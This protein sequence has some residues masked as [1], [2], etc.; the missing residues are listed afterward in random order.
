M[1]TAQVLLL[2]LWFIVVAD[3]R[4]RRPEPSRGARLEILH[5]NQRW[6]CDFADEVMCHIRN[7]PSMPM[8]FVALPNE[9]F[10]GRRGVYYLSHSAHSCAHGGARLYTP[11]FRLPPE[12]PACLE[13]SYWAFGNALHSMSVYQQDEGARKVWQRDNFRTSQD[14]CWTMAKINITPHNKRVPTRFFVE[15]KFG[16]I[17]STRAGFVLISKLSIMSHRCV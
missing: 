7:Q 13:L 15:A 14:D 12:W 3:S 4:H 8:N 6:T 2:A 11:Y 5:R 17:L 1:N 10:N 16:R 9:T